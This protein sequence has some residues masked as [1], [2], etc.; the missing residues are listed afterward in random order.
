[1]FSSGSR[2]LLCCGIS[3]DSP[4]DFIATWGIQMGDM[5]GRPSLVASLTG[6]DTT[7]VASID[8]SPSEIFSIHLY[9]PILGNLPI[10]VCSTDGS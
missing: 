4:R 9:M 2:L 1:M 10:L 6:G 7:G 8:D 5:M 3:P